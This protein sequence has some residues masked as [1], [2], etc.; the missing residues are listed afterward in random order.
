MTTQ[1]SPIWRTIAQ[2]TW[3]QRRRPTPTPTTDEATTWVVDTGAPS[4]EA[5]RITPADAVWLAS[6]SIGWMR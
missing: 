2:R 6:P 4:S 5:P 3:C 1:A